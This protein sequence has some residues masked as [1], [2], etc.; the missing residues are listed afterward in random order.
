[1]SAAPPRGDPPAPISGDVVDPGAPLLEVTGLRTSFATDRG[2]IA[3]VDGVSLTLARGQTLGVV[4]ETGSGKTVLTR[5]IMGLVPSRGVERTGSVL[6]EGRELV[7]LEE[8]ELARLWGRRMAL[9]FQD[10][11]TSLSPSLRIGRQ[12]TDGLRHHLKL[13]HKEATAEAVRL[14]TSVG[15]PDAAGRMGQFPHEL[16]GGLRQRVTIAM[17][18]SCGPSLLLADEPTTALDVTVQAQ[19]LDLL[20]RVCSE[21]DMGVILVSHDL[22][23]IASRTDTICVMYAGR[24][25]ER[26][27]T[28][29]L[30]ANPRMPYTDALMRSIPR[31]A[32]TPHAPLAAIGGR[33]PDL[34][35]LPVGC[36]FAPRCDHAR[37]ECRVEPPPLRRDP[38]GHEYACWFPVGEPRRRTEG[39]AGD[40]NGVAPATDSGA[41][42]PAVRTV[43][44]VARASA[45]RDEP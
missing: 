26:A 31:V 6:F 16:S 2:R 22:G 17:A 19:I 15:T 34:A 7:G 33:P 9:V 3:A 10:P 44:E 24:V 29:E 18:L 12:L 37:P 14:L 40:R 43:S 5:S 36:A 28:T 42:A 11:M 1:M 35:A 27:P 21:R 41:E 25:V 39:D 20:A 8:K 30:F 23:V 45:V 13:S 38:D 4:G 32:H